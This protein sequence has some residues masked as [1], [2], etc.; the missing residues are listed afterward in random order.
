M[1][2]RLLVEAGVRVA[3]IVINGQPQDPAASSPP[4]PIAGGPD[5]LGI[6]P[7]TSFGLAA[8]SGAPSPSD[9]SVESNRRWIERMT[10]RRVVAVLPALHQ[11]AINPARGLLPEAFV[12][13]LR[14]V[15]CRALFAP[16]RD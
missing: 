2:V 11:E 15:D 6:Q 13:P 16:P 14:D 4:P 10:G 9:P 3:G 5:P 1:T 8:G 7:A 12:G